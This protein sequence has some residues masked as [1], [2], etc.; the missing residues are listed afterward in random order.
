MKLSALRAL[1]PLAGLLAAIGCGG[2]KAPPPPPPPQV[3]H[4]HQL[5]SGNVALK[6]ATSSGRLSPYFSANVTARVSGVLL[7]AGVQGR[8]RRS[9]RGQVLFEIDPAYYQARA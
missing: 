7:E 8:A 2:N 9:K 3:E 4:D 5:S 6:A 1:F